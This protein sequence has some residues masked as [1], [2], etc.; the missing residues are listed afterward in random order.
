MGVNTR[1]TNE[2]GLQGDSWA[3]SQLTFRQTSPTNVS[4]R[5]KIEEVGV[6]RVR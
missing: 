3:S 2:W 1:E 5:A 6:V 4:R